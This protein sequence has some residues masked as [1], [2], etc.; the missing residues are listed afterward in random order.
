MTPGTGIQGHCRFLPHCVLE[1]FHSGFDEFMQHARVCEDGIDRS[2][3]TVRLGEYDLDRESEGE[4]DFKV[5]RVTLHP[6]YRSHKVQHDIAI[7]TLAGSTDDNCDIWRICLPFFRFSH[8]GR[9]ATV[10][11]WGETSNAPGAGSSN[12]L[13][14]V[15]VPVLSDDQCVSQIRSAYMPGKMLCAGDDAK[16]SCRGDSGGPL[17][18]E[19]NG[20]WT[21]FGIVAAGVGKE[22]ASGI[23]S[24][25]IRVDY[26]SD[27]IQTVISLV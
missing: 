7:L 19:V 8:F 25:Y 11:G 21:I 2:L 4:T 1:G 12:L 6:K 16:D 13:R 9:Q 10:I 5:D 26:Y 20:Q 27:W 14:E 23:P 22:C 24:L 18:V 15:E 17:M 3:L